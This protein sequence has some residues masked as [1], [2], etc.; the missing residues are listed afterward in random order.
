MPLLHNLFLLIKKLSTFF[1][2]DYLNAARS[3]S[4]INALPNGEAMYRYN[5]YFLLQ[6]LNLPEEIYETG[7]SE[8]TRITAEMEQLKNNIGY[9]GTL[10]NCST[11]C[12]PTNGLCLL[13]QLRKC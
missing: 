7:L 13:K 1:S 6:L 10:K 11:I 5:I 9:T 8:V 3:T 2:G 4:G 12:K